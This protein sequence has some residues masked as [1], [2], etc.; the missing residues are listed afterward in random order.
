MELEKCNGCKTQIKYSDAVDYCKD[1]LRSIEP[2]L[3]WELFGNSDENIIVQDNRIT[4]DTLS[5]DD[6]N[7]WILTFSKDGP[8]E[9]IK[10]Y[11]SFMR[12]IK[13]VH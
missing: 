2:N 3:Y 12:W 8:P 11:P 7:L 4:F 13:Y 10:S 1:C 6:F 5:K 9:S